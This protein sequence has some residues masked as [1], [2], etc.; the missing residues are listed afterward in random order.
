MSNSLKMKNN[1]FKKNQQLTIV[2]FF[3]G[4][5]GFSEGF[6]QMGFNIV[7]GYDHWMPAV[8]TFNHN[9][10]LQCEVK[11]I[12]DFENSIEEI[13]EIPNTSVILGSPP[14]VSFSSSN[15]SGKA[16]KK[17]GLRLIKTF[18][19]IVAVKKHQSNSTLE[20]WFMENVVNSKKHLQEVYT[21]ADLNLTEWALKNGKSPTC[22]ALRLLSNTF[23]INSADYGSYQSRKRAIS[24]EII[25]KDAFIVPTPTHEEKGIVLKPW[26]TLGQLINKLPSPSLRIQEGDITDPIYPEIKI[27]AIELTDQFYDS[28]LYECEWRQSKELKTN[29]HCMGRMSFPENTARPSRTVTATKSGTSREG[30]IYECD[31]NRTGDGEYRSPTIREI[32]SIMGF[33]I[34]YQFTGNL[35]TK[36]RQVGN[37]VCPSVSKALAKEFLIQG[38]YILPLERIL[39][40]EV[41]L[42]GIINL[43]NFSEA[44][45]TNPPKRT[46][47]SRYRRQ[48]IKDGNLTVTLSNYNILSKEKSAGKWFTSIQYGT[49]AN[50]KHQEVSDGFY[51]NLENIIKNEVKGGREFIKIINNG[52]SEKIADSS[53][54][55]KMYEQQ[56]CENGKREPTHL[57]DDLKQII[58]DFELD[59]EMY[60]QKHTNMI[61][62]FKEK[63]PVKQILALYGVNKITS[64]ANEQI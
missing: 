55:Q 9:F 53:L 35:Y 57:I 64:V 28:G 42:K 46:R 12:L 49:G 26:R 51:Q 17:L 47:N 13:D 45:F 40:K 58:E 19:R 24:G 1:I 63:I 11:N 50:F 41:N 59:K 54:M 31:Y 56:K 20:G 16:D 18:L 37:A 32:A 4:A 8:H 48:P 36:W 30:L 21:F 22:E 6:R 27:K 62:K 44:T 61:F 3:C 7:Q 29:H 23:I 25:S 39:Q 52:F 2:D 14:C 33:P 43:N 15:K 10:D 34:T 38:N 5:G 60:S